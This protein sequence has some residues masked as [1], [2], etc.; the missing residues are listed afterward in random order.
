MKVSVCIPNYNYARYIARTIRSVLVQEDPLEVVVSDNASTDASVPTIEALGDPRVRVTVNGCNVGFAGNLDRAA[1]LATG[2]LMIML[3]SD[4]LVRPGALAAY[5]RLAAPGAILSSALD[6]IDP[7]DK[8]TGRMGP[9]P[10]W[11]QADRVPELDALAGGPVYRVEAGELLRRSLLSM[12]NPFHFATTAYPRALYQAVEGY[13]GGRLMNP[14]KWFHWR[15]LGA[16]DQAYVVDHPHF[17]Y[18]WHPANQTAQQASSGALKFLVDEYVSTL[19]L[20]AKLLEKARLTRDEVIAAFVE[21]SVVR[22]ALATLAKGD[23]VRAR[24]TLEFGHSV[25]PAAL[26]KNWKAWTLAGLLALG[27]IGKR[28]A[29]EAY[30]RVMT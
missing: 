1:R 19:E 26:R 14:D 30:R 11:S 7:D 8:I 23:P 29:A 25:Y 17:A 20:D 15:L 18:R 9:E 5:R 28:V 21:H 3:S 6:V 13:G 10:V 2:D 4:D 24:R 27:P 22:H 12:K 16:A